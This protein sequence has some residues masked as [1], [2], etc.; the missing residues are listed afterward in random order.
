MRK[1]GVDHNTRSHKHLKGQNSA[2]QNWSALTGHDLLDNV[3][4]L[5]AQIHYC[6]CHLMTHTQNKFDILHY[7]PAVRQNLVLGQF[8]VIGE[9]VMIHPNFSHPFPSLLRLHPFLQHLH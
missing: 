2:T 6:H 8:A 1:I 9:S 3:R 4:N 5:L 7:L